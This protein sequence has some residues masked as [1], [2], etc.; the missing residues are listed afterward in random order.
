MENELEAYSQPALDRIPG[1][2]QSSQP[3]ADDVSKRKLQLFD[4]HRQRLFS[5]AYRMLGSAAD[6]DD[7][8]QE[9][10]LR[11]LQTST[12]AA[13]PEAFLVTIVTRLCLNH[14]QSARVKREE[15]F[16][17]WLP[18]P[19]LT[20]PAA[21]PSALTEMDDSISMAFLVLLERLTP[22][23]RAVFLLREIFEYEYSEISGIVEETPTNC[24]QILRRA[25]QHLKHSRTRFDSSPQKHEELLERFRQAS[26]NGDMEGLLAI[27]SKDIILYADGGG[28]ASA[29][30]NPIFGAKNVASLLIGA[31]RKLLPSELV[32]Q[33][34]QINGR[35]GILSYWRGNP[36]GVVTIEVEQGR[37]SAIYIVSNPDKLARLPVLSAKTC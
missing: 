21:G 18:E 25:R 8:L 10:A 13:S 26:A 29:V 28:K 14:L 19:L 22:K 36:Y 16:G 33:I 2:D 24:R 32:A 9:A 1:W 3:N 35:P 12:E 27:M 31:R 34:V 15:Y 17:Q 4:S 11:W 5:I 7:I 30:P 6:A 37:I 20:A 23:E